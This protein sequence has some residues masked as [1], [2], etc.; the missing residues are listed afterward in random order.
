[1]INK[2]NEINEI[3]I[4]EYKKLFNNTLFSI[5]SME[6]YQMLKNYI[7]Y[8]KNSILDQLHPS[9]INCLDVIE[10]RKTNN[11]LKTILLIERL[12]ELIKVRQT[13]NILNVQVNKYTRYNMSKLL[14]NSNSFYLCCILF[15]Y[16]FDNYHISCQGILETFL[17]NIFNWIKSEKTL[18]EL[19]RDRND[20]KKIF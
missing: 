1:M 2:C 6:T 20:I 14:N 4:M 8:Y 12:K 17:K 10:G 15:K 9:F 16:C 7:E 11:S 3:I 5:N 13:Q 18:R 19:K